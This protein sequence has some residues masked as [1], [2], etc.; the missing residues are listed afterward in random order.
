MRKLLFLWLVLSFLSPLAWAPPPG[1][2]PPRTDRFQVPRS[3]PHYDLEPRQATVFSSNTRD[4]YFKEVLL[5]ME[6]AKD[7]SL[8]FARQGKNWA[9]TYLSVALA[10]VAVVTGFSTAFQASKMYGKKIKIRNR[11]SV[12][13][14]ALATLASAGS[15][16]LHNESD[17]FVKQNRDKYSLLAID[18]N[19]VISDFYI[20]LRAEDITEVTLADPSKRKALV[21]LDRAT[22][23][24]IREL[25]K[26]YAAKYGI[27]TLPDTQ[28][29]G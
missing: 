3:E 29:S 17:S 9:L 18:I 25:A 11:I 27:N 19:E 16:Y 20:S 6:Q 15:L 22:S 28:K 4:P 21:D 23:A 26:S 24:R 7:E 5:N 2:S 13:L 12:S 10:I 14:A 1:L 8:Y